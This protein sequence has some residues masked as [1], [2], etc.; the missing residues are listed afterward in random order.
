MLTV[1]VTIKPYTGTDSYGDK[2][3]G[4]D[5][6][7]TCLPEPRFEMVPTQKDGVQNISRGM[8][9]VD[10]SINMTEHDLIVFEGT[11]YFIKY[12]AGFYD[13]T[14]VSLWQVTF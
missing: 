12:L 8:L 11:Q 2:L 14:H 3:Y 1:P 13:G 5:I 10:G 7:T 6:N 4:A 9:Y